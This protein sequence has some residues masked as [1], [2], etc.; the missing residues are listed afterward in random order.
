MQKDLQEIIN[1]ADELYRRRT[2]LM[3]VHKSV[4]LLEEALGRVKQYELYWRLSRSLFFLGQEEERAADGSQ[5]FQRGVLAAEAA[6]SLQ[7][8]LVA[9]QF[10]LGVNLALRAQVEGLWIALTRLRRAKRV[11]TIAKNIDQTFHSAGP[12]RVLGRIEHKVPR[13]L[14]GSRRRARECYERALTIAPQN[15]VTRMFFAELLI[16][17]REIEVARKELKYI[18][19]VEY[20]P[21]WE[22]EIA[23]DQIRAA[24]MLQELAK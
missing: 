19:A 6:T 15:T 3:A 9:G 14:G 13:V 24:Q 4:D 2:E 1:R 5:Y 22:F 7:A 17:N 10:W 20:D 16:E 8:D 18:L 21:E 23:R 12:L 11:L